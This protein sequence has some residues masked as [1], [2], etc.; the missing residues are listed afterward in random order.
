VHGVKG[1]VVS[2]N[3][4]RDVLVVDL[5]SSAK[6][7]E[8]ASRVA[9]L[10]KGLRDTVVVQD[11]AYCL[12]LLDFGRRSGRKIARFSQEL[13]DESTIQTVTAVERAGLTTE[14]KDGVTEDSTFNLIFMTLYAPPSRNSAPS[15]EAR[16]A[17]LAS[18]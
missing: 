5:Y 3:R 1:G 9:I 10:Q 11:A 14:E 16:R 4:G 2:S 15:T 12:L 8:N 7:E 17:A 18:R 13:V 6:G